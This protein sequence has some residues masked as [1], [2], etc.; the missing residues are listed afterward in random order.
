M[1]S[2]SATSGLRGR[3]AQAKCHNQRSKIY[4]FHPVPQGQNQ[5]SAKLRLAH[6][7]AM[8]ADRLLTGA[9]PSGATGHLMQFGDLT[10]G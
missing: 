7:E 3:S 9:R 1:A 8:T 2:T 4:A 5:P 10:Q 6:G